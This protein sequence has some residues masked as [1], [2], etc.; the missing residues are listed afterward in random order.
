MTETPSLRLN[1]P[2]FRLIA[3]VTAGALLNIGFYFI[4]FIA[5]PVLSGMVVG[6]LLSRTREGAIAG[7]TSSLISFLP[8]L[9]FIA[10]LLLSL[11]PVSDLGSFYLALLLYSLI[12]S[13]IGLVAGVI[14]SLIGA[15][16]HRN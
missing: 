7:F 5:T 15:R 6:F 10:P 12:L 14:G 2:V 8:L 9:L 4:L 13:F 16:T 11:N 1:I 3:I